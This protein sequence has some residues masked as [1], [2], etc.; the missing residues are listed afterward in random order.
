MRAALA[1]EAR[2][3]GRFYTTPA[4]TACGVIA[5]DERQGPP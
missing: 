5:L 3:A 4:V 2:S 1:P